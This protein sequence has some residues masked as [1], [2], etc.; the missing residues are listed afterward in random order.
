[1]PV[2]THKIDEALYDVVLIE[3]NELQLLFKAVRKNSN[4]RRLFIRIA[5]Y[6]MVLE[7]HLKKSIEEN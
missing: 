3:M 7:E 4:C 5:E 1:M 6:L 2:E